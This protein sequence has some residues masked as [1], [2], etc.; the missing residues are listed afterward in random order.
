MCLL[1]AGEHH[2]PSGAAG[3]PFCTS[4]AI[5]EAQPWKRPCASRLHRAHAMQQYIIHWIMWSTPFSACTGSAGQGRRDR[6]VW[7]RPEDQDPGE[8][9]AGHAVHGENLTDISCKQAPI[10]SFQACCRPRVTLWHTAH[11][12][13]VMSICTSCTCPHWAGA[14]AAG[15]GCVEQAGG[16]KLRTW[17]CMGFRAFQSHTGAATVVSTAL[18]H[19]RCSAC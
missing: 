12:L 2:I 6:P 10:S 5:L 14:M 7:P 11:V 3:A 8:W 13:E 18:S 9:S 17:A 19:S 15:P 16:S 1:I 4:V